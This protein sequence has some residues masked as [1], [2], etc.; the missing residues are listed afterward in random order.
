M[1][2]TKEPW[3]WRDRYDFDVH[4]DHRKQGLDADCENIRD[5]RIELVNK[6]DTIVLEE[7]DDFGGDSGLTVS[8]EDAERIVACVNACAGINPKAVSL[9]FNAIEAML[10]PEGGTE[11]A[12][13]MLKEALA[14]AKDQS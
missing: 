13:N 7:W 10:S 5:G 6:D 14:K 1:K 12:F 11:E 8:H 3:M 4:Q 2:H 9:M